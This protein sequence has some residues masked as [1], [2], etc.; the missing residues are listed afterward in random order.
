MSALIPRALVAVVVLAA[1][2]A[3][4]RAEARTRVVLI[5]A[6][7]AL[8]AALKEALAPWHAEVVID[9]IPV[10]DPADAGMRA[11]S[12]AARFVIWRDGGT[13]VVY[14][15]ERGDL[16]RRGGTAGTL[17]PVRASAAALTVKTMMRLPPPPTDDGRD[18]RVP[19]P[20]PPSPGRELRAEV[21]GGLGV[22]TPTARVFAAIAVQP[23]RGLGLRVGLA[24]ELGSGAS[25]DQSGFSGTWR[26]YDIAAFASFVVPLGSAFE[27]EPALGLGASLTTL[28]GTQ[29]GTTRDDNLTV[30]ALF[31]GVTG[32]WRLPH[33]GERLS[34]F[35]AL[36][37][38]ALPTTPSYTRTNGGGQTQ[39]VFQ[40]PGI[41]ATFA[42]GASLHLGL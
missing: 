15:R 6:D 39:E 25:V 26:A 42:I 27:L 35:V 4:A 9:L 20:P 31:G 34:V 21:G 23:I 3:P 28:S 16:Q 33:T 41:A 1:A 7:G 14:D 17:D 11:Q 10:R 12:W 37:A 5:D 40:A 19:P 24:N 32:R 22:P 13:L 30:L 8:A 2:A 36:R 18:D 29:N 38:R